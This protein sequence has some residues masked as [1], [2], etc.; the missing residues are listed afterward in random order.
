[1]STPNNTIDT[2]LAVLGGGPGGYT[3]AFRAADLGLRTVLIERHA[4]LGGV[5]LNVG[6]IPSKALLHVA[7][8]IDQA[9]H[10]GDFGLA[11]NS[12]KIEFAKTREWKEG[13]VTQLTDGLSALAKQRKVQVVHGAGRFVSPNCIT[14][15]SPDG[16][17]T[18]N[19]E[20]AIIAAGS[21]PIAPPSLS[22]DDARVMDSTDAL[23]LTDIPRRMLIIGGGIIG[24]EMATVYRAFGAKISVVEMADQLMPGADTDLLRPLLKRIK[25][26]YEN[27]WLNTAV[28]KM[29]V[30]DNGVTVEFE[31]ASKNDSKTAAKNPP[32]PQTFDKVLVAVGRAPNGAQVSA[33]AAGVNVDERGFIAVDK[34]QRTNVAHIFAVGDVVGAPM[35]A[36]KATHE[37]KVAAEVA[38]GKKSGFDARVIPSVA[39]TNP[40]VAWV[41][42]TETEAKQRGID[43]G[44]GAFPWAASGRAL[45]QGKDGVT[46]LLF[47]KD[48]GR[49]LGAGISGA[50]AGDLINEAALA[51]E[52][53]ADA[54]DIGLTIHAH[55]TFAETLGLAAEAHAGV[56]TDLYLPKKRAR[57]KS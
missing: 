2:Q 42:L 29:Q 13:V 4:K 49:L 25:T 14:V 38:A 10:A 35:L 40:E 50:H 27:I 3:A 7:E 41:G 30:D 9:E 12:A 24:L 16:G 55:P 31:S 1:M 28:S 54:E 32:P 36:H 56:I 15:D 5:C 34:Q 52:M 57:G 45:S 21:S 11:F 23:Q 43:Y 37:G 22:H 17:I 46:K 44:K 51:I 48:D 18:V 6:C 20:Q 26:Q 19:F 39:Y 47:D 53:N 33:Q 8:V